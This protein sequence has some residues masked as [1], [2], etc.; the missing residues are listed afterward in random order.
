[1][2]QV[3]STAV[4]LCLGMLCP[5]LALLATSIGTLSSVFELLLELLLTNNFAELHKLG[6]T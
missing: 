1:M 6:R 5:A 2:T 3:H 4:V